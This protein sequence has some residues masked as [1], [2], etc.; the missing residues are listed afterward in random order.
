[1]GRAWLGSWHVNLLH[2]ASIVALTVIRKPAACSGSLLLS[3][4]KDVSPV[5]CVPGL[6]GLLGP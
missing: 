2:V 6:C 1:M 5:L 3:H 4:T